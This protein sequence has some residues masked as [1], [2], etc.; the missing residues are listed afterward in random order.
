MRRRVLLIVG[1]IGAGKSTVS[2]LVARQLREQGTTSVSVDLDDVVFMQKSAWHQDP[3]WERGRVAH[4]ALVGAWLR[5][6]IEVVVAHGPI[7][8]ER[9]RG[10]LM[11]EAPDTDLRV[12]LLRVP[13]EESIRRVS[14]DATRQPE[15][16][17]RVVEFL[18]GAD[19]RFQSVLPELEASVE[20]D[21]DTA[22]LDPEHIAAVLCREVG[23]TSPNGR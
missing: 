7:C 1:P 4:A 16:Q 21:F 14:N 13:L 3:E 9:E 2:D 15:A 5:A 22:T 23:T 17:S 20:W 18:R 12:A 11:S 10:V 8:T 6:G 19:A